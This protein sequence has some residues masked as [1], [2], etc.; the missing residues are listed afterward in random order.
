M[1]RNYQTIQIV[2]FPD[3]DDAQPDSPSLAAPILADSEP[4]S[5]PP[6]KRGALLGIDQGDKFIGV[7]LAD[8][9]WLTA[10]P[11]QILPRR[12][13][14]VD[15]AAI[16]TLIAKYAVSALVVG[17]PYN[18]DRDDSQAEGPTRAST[19]RRWATRLAAAVSIPLYLHDESFSSFEA[20]LTTDRDADE[21]IDDEAAVLILESFINAHLLGQPLP[22]PFK[23]RS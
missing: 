13:N 7:A 2:S 22:K 9:L 23:H 21:R 16:N 4:D 14:A 17:M 19:V 10:R 1:P 6:V 5:P 12:S 18:P 15:F 3:P 8:G 11:L 20:E